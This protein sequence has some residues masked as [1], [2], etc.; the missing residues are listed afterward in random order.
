MKKTD[1]FKGTLKLMR[2]YTPNIQKVYNCKVRIYNYVN[3]AIIESY[4]TYVGVFYRPSSSLFVFD[5]YSATT[6][7]HI[8]KVAKL[9]K[10]DR[11]VYLY[12]R[13][14]GVIEKGLSRY[15]NTYRLRMKEFNKVKESDFLTYIPDNLFNKEGLK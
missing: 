11:I 2:K 8:N 4:R 12:R 1:L 13:S 14:D 5:Y 9:L 7:Q 6:Y 10:A 3:V 15:A